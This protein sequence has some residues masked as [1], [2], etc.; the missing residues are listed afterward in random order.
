VDYQVRDGAG[1]TSAASRSVAVVDTLRPALT[2]LGSN[3]ATVECATAYRD[4]GALAVDTCDG[5]ITRAIATQSNVNTRVPGNYAVSYQVHD[6]AG[7]ISAASRSVVVVDHAPP[8]VTVNPM[9]ELF[10][11]DL[12]YRRF[13]LSDCAQAFDACD[14]AT[15][16]DQ[17]GDIVAI[18]SDEP[19]DVG[20]G[21]PSRDIVILGHSSFLVRRQADEHRNGRVYEIEFT[22]RDARGNRS[23]AHSCFIGVETRL[24]RSPINDG[25]VFTVRP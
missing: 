22:T 14:G 20:P 12:Q 4:A 1:L 13:E 19:D 23:E 9:R 2:V 11:S 16:I 17:I 10:P 7:L 5:D 8:E 15:Q 18:H 24:G 6:I 3:P 25:R 21:D